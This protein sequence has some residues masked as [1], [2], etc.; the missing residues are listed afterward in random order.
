MSKASKCSGD[1]K[2][3]KRTSQANGVLSSTVDIPKIVRDV[4]SDIRTNGDAAVRQY[5]DKFDKWS[6]T[7]FKLSPAAIDSII[8]KVSEQTLKDIITVQDNVRKFALAQRKTI[9]DLEVEIRPGVILGHKN[10]PIESV[11][12]LVASIYNYCI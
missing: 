2:H 12:A 5:S 1:F 7:S 10:I 6:P 3:L 4:I 8:S 9:T 11:G